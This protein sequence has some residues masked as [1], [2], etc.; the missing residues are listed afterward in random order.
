MPDK[1]GALVTLSGVQKD[2]HGLRPLRVQRLDLHPARTIAVVGVDEVMAEVIVNLITGAAVPDIGDVH[3]FGR[4]TTD[5]PDADAWLRGLDQF[6]LLSD[7]AVLLDQMTAEQNLAVPLSMELEDLPAPIRSAV[8]SL[9]AEVGI[10]PLALTQVTSALQPRIR[11]RL[12]LARALALN[13]RVLLAEHPNAALPAADLP[14]FAG[15]FVR[16]VSARRLATL[17]LTAD[18]TF[19][20]SVAD[21][22]LTLNQATGALT[23]VS[24]WRRWFS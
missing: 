5:I 17:V 9:A 15:H 19:A 14:E 16:V 3:A 21:E 10:E 12:R 13:P 4:R 18:R 6:G 7:R 8:A 24:G 2:Y 23:S 22:V 1:A 20:V 11:A